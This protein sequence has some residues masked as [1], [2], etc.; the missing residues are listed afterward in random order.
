MNFAIDCFDLGFDFDEPMEPSIGTPPELWLGV[1]GE[2]EEERTA[3]LQAASDILADEPE[4]MDLVTRMTVA[5]I[6]ADMP[7]LFAAHLASRS[8]A[9]RSTRPLSEGIA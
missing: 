2:S 8:S 6:E 4:L 9:G 3:R 1:P 7:Y 5:A